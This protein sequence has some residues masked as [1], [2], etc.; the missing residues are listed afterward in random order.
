MEMQAAAIIEASDSAPP[1]GIAVFRIDDCAFY[2]PAELERVLGRRKLEFLRKWGLSAQG[3]WYFGENVLEA[4][5]RARKGADKGTENGANQKKE[6]V[7]VNHPARK[8]VT[9]PRVKGADS[10]RGQLEEA[11]R[12][13]RSAKIRGERP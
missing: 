8:P 3:G 6:E 4:E 1:N 2:R 10:L 12:I 13:V 7:E 5:R 11:E 9:V